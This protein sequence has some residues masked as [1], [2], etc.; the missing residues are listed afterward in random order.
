MGTPVG[1]EGGVV[2]TVGSRR[3]PAWCTGVER[4][5]STGGQ[6]RQVSREPGQV[7]VSLNPPSLRCQPL[8]R[9]CW[10]PTQ[11]LCPHRPFLLR[12]AEPWSCPGICMAGMQKGCPRCHLSVCQCQHKHSTHPHSRGGGRQNTPGKV[13]QVRKKRSTRG[14]SP[15]HQWTQ[16]SLCRMPGTTIATLRPEERWDWCP[17]NQDEC[18]GPKRPPYYTIAPS[19]A[20]PWLLRV[21]GRSHC[22]LLQ[23]APRIASIRKMLKCHG[24]WPVSLC[25]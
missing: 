20:P 8:G 25:E 17:G 9:C 24:G 18:G 14:H 19:P 7:D 11:V 22:H 2:G 12:V 13:F 21:L 5:S 1:P 15:H 4:H 3:A 23:K 6:Q 10:L 16:F